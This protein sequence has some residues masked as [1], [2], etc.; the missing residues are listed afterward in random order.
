VIAKAYRIRACRFSGKNDEPD[1]FLKVPM[2]SGRILYAIDRLPVADPT[3]RVPHRDQSAAAAQLVARLGPATLTSRSHSR[4]M[5]TA[6]AG[7]ALALGIDIE[8]RKPGRDFANLARAFLERAPDRMTAADFY[9]GW[10]FHEAYYKAFQRFPG[11]ADVSAVLAAESETVTLTGG[12]Q[13]LQRGVAQMFQLCL[14]WRAPA[15]CVAQ[16]LAGCQA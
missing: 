3:G 5:I 12:T 1:R 11:E 8:W 7:D 10:T 2:S 16:E 15:P 9:R 4:G 6:A 14:V 13:V